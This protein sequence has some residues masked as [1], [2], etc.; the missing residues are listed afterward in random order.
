MLVRTMNSANMNSII[1]M[2]NVGIF[3]DIFCYE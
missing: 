2:N 1:I 3:N